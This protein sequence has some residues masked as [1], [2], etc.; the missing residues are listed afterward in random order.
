[1]VTPT[2]PGHNN[3]LIADTGLILNP[4][5]LT[6]ELPFEGAVFSRDDNH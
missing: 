2:T 3:L 5:A 6:R 1:M 4:I